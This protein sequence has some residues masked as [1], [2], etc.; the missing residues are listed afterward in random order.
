MSEDDYV[1]EIIYE[2][3]V[4][5]SAAEIFQYIYQQLSP[6][7]RQQLARLDYINVK[8][9]QECLIPC[10]NEKCDDCVQSKHPVKI[11]KGKHPM[12]LELIPEEV[13]TNELIEEINFIPI[14]TQPP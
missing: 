8:L 12:I 14:S 5:V 2:S 3:S 10:D 1:Q 7:R 11:D 9:C 6:N 13:V 4:E